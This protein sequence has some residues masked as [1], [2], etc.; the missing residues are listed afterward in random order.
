MR[1]RAAKASRSTGA[2]QILLRIRR[3][4]TLH[5]AP[6]VIG[7]KFDGLVLP[8][9]FLIYTG[10]AMGG[11]EGRLR[12]HF[13]TGA[14][15]QWHLDHLTGHPEVELVGVMRFPSTRRQE[16][17]LA[18]ATERS[19][20]ARVPAPGFGNGDK[21][22]SKG[23]CRCSSHLVHFETRPPGDWAFEYAHEESAAHHR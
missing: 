11:I 5:I 16:C 23:L 17:E 19:P 21:S 4:L 8:P 7:H 18:F 12:Q 22:K 15:R 3:T 9:G 1:G 20:G 2:Y 6:S 10:S 13:T 14:R